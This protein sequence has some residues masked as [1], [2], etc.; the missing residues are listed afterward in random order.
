MHVIVLL[1]TRTSQRMETSLMH[2][3]ILSFGVIVL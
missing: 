3:R 2:K 1:N